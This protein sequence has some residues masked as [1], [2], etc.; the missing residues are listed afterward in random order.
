MASG[1]EGRAAELVPELGRESFP[2][3]LLALGISSKRWRLVVKW[4]E[5]GGGFYNLARA[6]VAVCRH[7]GESLRLAMCWPSGSDAK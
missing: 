3:L 6:A 4:G 5:A 7:W 2:D 1:E